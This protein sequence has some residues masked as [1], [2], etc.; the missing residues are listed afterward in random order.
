M[1]LTDP[2]QQSPELIE[3]DEIVN[4]ENYPP[5]PAEI[6][7]KWRKGSQ[8][9]HAMETESAKTGH[10]QG[11]KECVRLLTEFEQSDMEDVIIRDI[12]IILEIITTFDREDLLSMLIRHPYLS[13]FLRPQSTKKKKENSDDDND[14]DDD[15]DD[16]K[17]DNN[18]K[19]NAFNPLQSALKKA[20]RTGKIKVLNY[21]ITQDI[22]PIEL[23]D[24]KVQGKQYEIDLKSLLFNILR[25][26]QIGTKKN[27]WVSSNCLNCAQQFWPYLATKVYNLKQSMF[28]NDN[29][30]D[31]TNIGD[32]KALKRLI[33]VNVNNNDNEIDSVLIN[34]LK[35]MNDDYLIIKYLCMFMNTMFSRNRQINQDQLVAISAVLQFQRERYITFEDRKDII[36]SWKLL[37]AQ[38]MVNYLESSKKQMVVIYNNDDDDYFN[39]CLELEMIDYLISGGVKLN[40]EDKQSINDHVTL[41]KIIENGENNWKLKSVTNAQLQQ[42]MPD[43]LPFEINKLILHMLTL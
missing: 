15:D 30:K 37:V 19:K 23:F 1:S 4:N 26:V 6:V 24:E 17:N 31:E 22:I 5:W 29:N 28:T 32:N 39:D 12:D 41:L 7:S 14:D 3:F 40:D 9:R 25:A 43:I 33:S 13:T 38:L 18:K 2:D 35:A 36:N 10:E 16:N 34:N 8:L 42:L 11:A 20:I 27:E 21:I